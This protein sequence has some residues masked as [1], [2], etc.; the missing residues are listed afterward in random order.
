MIHCKSLWFICTVLFGVV[1]NA[2]T[3]YEVYFASR[4]HDEYCRSVITDDNMLSFS[5]LGKALKSDTASTLIYDSYIYKISSSGDTSEWHHE[6]IDTV[7]IFKEIFF[8]SD[9][10]II[11]IG[12]GWNIDD[13]YMPDKSYQCFYK[14]DKSFNLI[15]EKKYH[16]VFPFTQ[17]EKTAYLRL[18]N[19]NY[20]YSSSSRPD[21]S[22]QYY[23]YVFQFSDEGDSIRYHLFSKDYSSTSNVSITY[24]SDSTKYWFHI[25]NGNDLTQSTIRKIEC[26]LDFNVL[27]SQYYPH[28]DFMTPFST[29]KASGNGFISA[30]RYWLF[31][32]EMY[33][34]VYKFDNY[35]N[36]LE[37]IDLTEPDPEKI[38]DPSWLDCIDSYYPDRIFVGGMHDR[39]GG[40]LNPEP[41]WIYIACLNEN[42]DMIYEEYLGGDAYYNMYDIT[43]TSD[44][45]VI[46]CGDMYI[47]SIQDNERDGYVIK[48]DSMMFV[49]LL[50]ISKQD[51]QRVNIFPNPAVDR[52]SFTNITPGTELHLLSSDGS[53]ILKVISRTYNPVINISNLP[54][55]IYIY[56]VR[57]P[58]NDIY[59]GKWIKIN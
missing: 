23:T 36:L 44:G 33:I 31:N 53:S 57:L 14:L 37:S 50:E 9:D 4:D 39:K 6:K 8:T 24:N 29:K 2:Q 17:P 22:Y 16:L 59:S 54:S 48:Y 28:Q 46:I 38:T 32:D 30:G 7:I 42:L 47:D 49:K 25:K 3:S 41:C 12:T 18:K 5:I 34:K 19:G 58:D 45:G 52:I 43:A 15:W 21:T 55:G 1:G 10:N 20:L 27:S 35:F 56:Q 26:D 13:Y 40:F 51:S 11:I